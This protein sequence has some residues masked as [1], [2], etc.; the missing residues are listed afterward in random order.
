MNKNESSKSR[1]VYGS[2]MR[3]SIAYSVTVGVTM[4]RNG[5]EDSAGIDHRQVTVQL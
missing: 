2:R 3:D 1:L 5:M 4:R